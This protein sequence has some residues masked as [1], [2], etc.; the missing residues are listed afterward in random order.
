[1]GGKNW[2][3]VLFKDAET[4]AVD[5]E[6]DPDNPSILYAAFLH[7]VPAPFGAPAKADTT[8]DAALCKS[9]DQGSTWKQVEGKGLPFEQMGRMGI[10]VAPGT[11]GMRVY[12]IVTQGLFRSDDGGANWQR[13]TTD[14]RVTG[15][16]YF[17]RVFVDP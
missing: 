12:A 15:N 14:P 5:L 2:Q 1:D 6:S 4:N 11:N 7:S 3:K 13:S 9:T 17:S 10:A 8:Q 16:G